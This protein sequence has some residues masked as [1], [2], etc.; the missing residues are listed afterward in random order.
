MPWHCRTLSLVQ[1][2][3]L[4]DIQSIHADM[5]NGAGDLL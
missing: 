1:D 4:E 5:F 3:K 2:T